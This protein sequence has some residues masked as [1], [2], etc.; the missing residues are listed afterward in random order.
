MG[1]RAGPARAHTGARRNRPMTQKPTAIEPVI[2]AAPSPWVQASLEATS[3]AE[4]PKPVAASDRPTSAAPSERA[5]QE[6]PAGSPLGPAA[7]IKPH[8]QQQHAIQNNDQ[9]AQT[10]LSRAQA[11]LEG[12][13]SSGPIA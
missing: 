9:R 12:A 2:Q 3:K 1:Q 6:E 13:R 11:A 10:A 8:R 7:E 5:R 4:P